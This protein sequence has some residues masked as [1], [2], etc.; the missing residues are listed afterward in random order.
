MRLSETRRQKLRYGALALAIVLLAAGVV[1]LSHRSEPA[2]PIP[3]VSGQTPPAPSGRQAATDAPGGASDTA[4]SAAVDEVSPINILRRDEAVELIAEAR[5][6]A[7]ADDFSAAEAALARASRA[8]PNL[9]EVGQARLDIAR[10]KTPEGKFALQLQRARMAIDHDDSAAAEAALDEAAQ[11]RP[12][13][14]QV[15]QLRADLQA[16]HDK[17]ARREARIAEALARMREAVTRH[18]FGAAYS[19]L[20]EAERIDVQNPTI[21]R[22][23]GELA[24]ARGAQSNISD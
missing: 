10:L 3:A 22:A 2:A 15:G 7:A 17:K 9:P 13:A 23:R 18:D 8:A 16:A 20:N 11:L 21:R 12:D 5:R 1:F 19:A 4:Q 24:R 14:P 6:Q